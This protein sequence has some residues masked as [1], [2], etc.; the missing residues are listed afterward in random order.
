MA[1]L[2]SS[3]NTVSLRSGETWS[4][5]FKPGIKNYLAKLWA[6]P[7]TE[8]LAQ[9]MDCDDDE[10]DRLGRNVSAQQRRQALYPWF[11]IDRSWAGVG[12]FDSDSED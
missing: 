12:T 9:S 3:D 1:D 4:I 2:M 10:Y 6:P 7:W 8:V 5:P 11:T